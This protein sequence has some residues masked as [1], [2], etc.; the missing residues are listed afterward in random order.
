M[1]WL[2]A[3]TKNCNKE[4]WIRRATAQLSRLRCS[5]KELTSSNQAPIL[6][7]CI[8]WIQLTRTQKDTK[9]FE[10]QIQGGFILKGWAV[11][12]KL[13]RKKTRK[14]RRIGFSLTKIFGFSRK[15]SNNCNHLRC[16]FLSRTAREILW[17]MTF[18][19]LMAQKSLR[20]QE[21]CR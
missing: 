5:C 12:T 11:T 19:T 18:G 14:I 16:R 15:A 3:T 2:M 9:R 4:A 7:R 6:I 17:L 8:S 21:I 13:H 1:V 10:G 20:L